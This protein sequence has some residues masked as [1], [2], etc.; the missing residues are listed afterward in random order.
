MG[1][2]LDRLLGRQSPH[3]SQG[4]ASETG[5]EPTNWSESQ[6]HLALLKRFL[7]AREA[8]EGFPDYWASVF[9]S[10]A[11]HLL[12]E[13]IALGA[14]E[15][16][17]LAE[18][19]EFC[20]TVPELKPLL[21]SRGLKVSGNKAGLIR[22]L[23]EADRRGTEKLFS[24]RI[25]LQCT[26][27]ARQ[28]IQSWETEL[29]VAFDVAVDEVIAALRRRRFKEAIGS[30]DAYR[31]TRFYPPVPPA[32]AAMTVKP[33]PRSVEER[34]NDIAKAF[35]LRPKILK[36]LRTEHW[37]GLYLNYAIWELLGRTAPERCMPGYI[38]VG[39]LDSATATQMLSHHI[40]H[41]RDVDLYRKFGVRK[42][43]ITG[44]GRCEACAALY[45]K[46]FSIDKLPA[47]P[48]EKCT[49]EQGCI[50]FATMLDKDGNFST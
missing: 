5:T 26:S 4:L 12:N 21:S 32:Q 43:R 11:A 35:T 1:A 44:I 23:I 36:G 27:A 10:N 31:N 50:C 18:T 38:G 14:L 20:H 6:L 24:R 49:C 33:A 3:S 25:I 29:L 45:N 40:K 7:K 34:A 2:W 16:L 19:V 13:M 46:T 42:A 8:E 30:A 17:P 48:Y 9:G 22:R 47:L 41:L 28:A 39:V 15:R 37:E